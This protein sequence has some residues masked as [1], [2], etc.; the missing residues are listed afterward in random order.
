MLRS[1]P[2]MSRGVSRK[3]RDFADQ[4]AVGQRKLLLA[5]VLELARR[6]NLPHADLSLLAT[7]E[8]G[9]KLPASSDLAEDLRRY[10]LAGDADRVRQLIIGNYRH[11]RAIE[12]LAD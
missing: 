10:L 11:G 12:A 8:R 9:L 3:K 7:P 4:T 6:G 1:H 5:D 2:T